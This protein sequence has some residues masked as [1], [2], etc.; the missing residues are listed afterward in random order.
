MKNVRQTSRALHLRTEASARFERGVD[1]NLAWIATQRAVA[2]IQEMLPEA[3]VSGFHDVYPEPREPFELTCPRSEIKRLL[4]VDF[5][6]D[7]V[8]DIL[9]RLDFQPRIDQIDGEPTIVVQ[10][11]TWRSDVTLKADIVEEVARIAGYDKL[12]ETL[13]VGGT[14]P[15]E[16]DPKRRLVS[17]VQDILSGTGLQEI[18]TYS[19]IND[20]DLE[21][22]APGAEQAPDRFG[23]FSKPALPLVRVTNP[24]RSDWELMRPTLVPSIL[25]NAAENLKFSQRVN[26][27]EVARVYQPRGI[28]ELPDERQTVTLLMAGRQQPAG[29]YSTERETDFFDAKGATDTLLQRLGAADV[30]YAPIDHASLHP[31]R[32][33]EIS[34]A[35]V[36]VGI[37]GEIHPVV[38]AQFGI[39]DHGRIAIAEIDLVALLETGLTELQARPISRSQPVDQDF[40]VVVDEDVPAE[41]VRQAIAS[42]AGFLL[43]GARL[44]DIY[45]GPAI[46]EGKKSLA[47]RVT[48]AAPDRQLREFEV[49]KLRNQIERQI[50][51]QVH[52]SLRA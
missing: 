43:A 46:A 7:E 32:S 39:S 3:R 37:I 10:V 48:F 47:Y 27:F 26:I 30:T 28:D 6:D 18:M 50:K 40:A 11:P 51:R 29:L 22:L 42:G 12:P 34:A 35:G 25:K 24:L 14:V 16:I 38:A 19:M 31:G 21:S 17:A 36:P 33:A 52:G 23:F 49:E 41:N 8:L 15:I 4:G 44:F 1:P 13:P 45:R 20:H 9:G 5:S 2:L